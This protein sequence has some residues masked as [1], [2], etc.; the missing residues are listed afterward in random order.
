MRYLPALKSLLISFMD[1]T[2]LVLP[3]TNYAEFAE[4]KIAELKRIEVGL[5]GS[6]LCLNERD[7]HISI[8]GLVSASEP[9]MEMAASVVATRNG[10]R[11]TASKA[12]ASRRNGAKGGRPRK[13]VAS[14]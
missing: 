1:R 6:A 7:L 13:T 12:H 2:A 9:L 5:A 3:V 11:S 8:A 14:G 10:Q 4:L